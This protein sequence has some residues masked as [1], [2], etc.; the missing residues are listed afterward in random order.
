M[1]VG[2][3]KRIL[4]LLN[5][6]AILAIGGTAYGWWSHRSSLQESWQAED[7]VVPVKQNVQGSTRIDQITMRLGQYPRAE[8]VDES[9]V[10]EQPEEAIQTVLDQ[11]GEILSAIVIYGPDSETR[12]AIVFRRRGM[13]EEEAIVTVR[14]GEAL[15]TRP[16]PD[17]QRAA[18]GDTVPFRYKFVR[19]EPDPENPAWTY[20]LFDMACDG[21]DIQK[22]R[23]TGEG[24]KEVLPTAA[25]TVEPGLRNTQIVRTGDQ[26]VA[27]VAAPPRER[28]ERTTVE[29]VR[30]VAPP[31]PVPTA[32]GELRGPIF[33]QEA[34]GFAPTD[35]GVRY[36]KDNYQKLLKDTKMGTY[37]D[38]R[39]GKAKG[40]HIIRIRGGSPA[41][42][43]GIREDDVILRINNTP[44]TRQSQA[45]NVVKAELRKK[46]RFIEV[47]ILRNGREMTL[48]FDTADAET[49]RRARDAFRNRR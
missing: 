14:A 32:T 23:W 43:F 1:S 40:V 42:E 45:V 8:P 33:E 6:V 18:W 3:A 38:K 44:V 2:L 7:W 4:A 48:R 22:A 27:T 12:S 41:N 10:E 29:P 15:E 31:P 35:E 25:G 34:G 36:L 11:Y 46:E 19:C 17:P 49:R 13:P 39:T 20:F 26:P 16:H 47:L 21:T 30:P 5:I 9:P 28:P 24:E 37:T